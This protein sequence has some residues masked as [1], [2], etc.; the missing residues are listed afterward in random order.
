MN[1]QTLVSLIEWLKHIK[2]QIHI[3]VLILQS[4]I[5]D[6]RSAKLAKKLPE[7]FEFFQKGQAKSQDTKL[8]K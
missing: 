4:S 5:D 3:Q 1:H 6:Q 8:I 2:I 7:P